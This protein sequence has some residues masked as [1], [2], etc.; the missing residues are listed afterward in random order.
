MKKL[1]ILFLGLII[2]CAC[3][4]NNEA[5]KPAVIKE[6]KLID[7]SE[8]TWS[9]NCHINDSTSIHF[10]LE[11]TNSEFVIINHKER[12]TISDPVFKNDSLFL[13]MP[14]FDSEFKA[15]I[16]SQNSFEGQW[17]NNLR[18][19]YHIPF[20]ANFIQAELIEE[21]KPSQAY[22]YDVKFSP[23]KEEKMW[24]AIGKFNKGTS[25]AYGTFLTETGDFRFL[26][27]RM[28][29]AYLELSCFDGSHLFLFTADV[30]NDSLCNGKF[31]SGNHY[32]EQWSAIKK[33]DAKLS[34]PDSL[35][36][37]IEQDQ[38]VQF[39]VLN[40]DGD[41]IFFDQKAYLNK[42]TL[43]QIFGSWC[44]N[45][46]DENIFYK[47]LYSEFS[48]IGLQIIPVAFEEGDDFHKQVSAVTGQFDRL[49][50]P[51]E[52]YIGGERTKENASKKFNML[53]K[54]ISYPTTIFI[55]KQGVV[56][57]IHTGFYGPGTGQ[58][59]TDYVKET[60]ALISTLLME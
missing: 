56:R 54:I 34:H 21:S 3:V 18:D 1:S 39:G 49:Q 52:P 60:R 30:K 8:G 23:S 15:K 37:L 9:V 33:E 55:D 42:V 27:G 58:Y 20:E 25:Y 6:S 31:Y 13:K 2:L 10:R 43:V 45:C 53:N 40:L 57:K 44:P 4:P 51:Y 16:T 36:Y 41:S 7:L 12:I 38:P 5:A 29:D 35:T 11:L 46:Y 17:T 47:E 26:E 32:H 22:T 50:M 14:R 24:P 19:D 59:Y 48:E 28:T